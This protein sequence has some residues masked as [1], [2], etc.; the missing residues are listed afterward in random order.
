MTRVCVEHSDTD[1]EVQ[2]QRDCVYPRSQSGGSLSQTRIEPAR[3]GVSGCWRLNI[4]QNSSRDSAI[5]QEEPCVERTASAS[6]VVAQSMLRIS[7]R[8]G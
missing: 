4:G 2:R 1:V 8:G 3:G 7:E 6:L 5:D